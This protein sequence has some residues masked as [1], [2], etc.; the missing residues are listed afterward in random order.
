MACAH[1]K[2]TSRDAAELQ[3]SRDTRNYFLPQ[4][5]WSK[6]PPLKAG[7]TKALHPARIAGEGYRIVLSRRK[8]KR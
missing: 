2:R 4:G 1:N 8:T 6:H 5:A 7:D 3:T